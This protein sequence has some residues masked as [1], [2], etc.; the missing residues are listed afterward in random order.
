P[1]VSNSKL[2]RQERLHLIRRYSAEGSLAGYDAAD[3]LLNAAAPSELYEVLEALNQ[4]LSER[5]GTPKPP[6]NALFGEAA[7]VQRPQPETALREYA[8]V[9]GALRTRVSALW[10]QAKSDSLREKLALRGNV[11]GVE[12]YLVA[13]ATGTGHAQD[14]RKA[15]LQ[16]LEEL[17]SAKI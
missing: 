7:K 9:T 5:A 1:A 12:E 13:Q 15:A 4:G 10:T 8:P 17:C 11:P 16:V 14:E 2:A 3:T 6:D